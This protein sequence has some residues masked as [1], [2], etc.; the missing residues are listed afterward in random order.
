MEGCVVED[1]EGRLG[2][3][4]EQAFFEPLIEET[5]IACSFKEKRSDQAIL[6]VGAYE[7]CSWSLGGC[8]VADNPFSSDP[9]G[10]ETAGCWRK[11]CLINIGRLK[12]GLFKS[13]KTLDKVL[14]PL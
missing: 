4:L 11:S 8:T 1:D 13:A 10:V 14:R 3:F 6:L 9:S 12:I 2:E 5:G 7:V